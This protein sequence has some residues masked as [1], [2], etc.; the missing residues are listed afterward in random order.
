MNNAAAMYFKEEF[1]M[2]TASAAAVASVFGWMNLFARGLGGFVS[3]KA[4]AK[5]GMKGRLLWQTI[6]LF[7]E[8]VLVIVFA[9]SSK[10][11]YA[12]LTLICFS[13]FVQAGE[14]STYGVVPYVNPPVTGSV[15]GIVGAGGNVGAVVFGL[16]FQRLDSKLAFV[17]M[18]VIIIISSSFSF[19]V[20]IPGETR[21]ALSSCCAHQSGDNVKGVTS[22]DDVNELELKPVEMKLTNSAKTVPN[23][24][25]L[26]VDSDLM[27]DIEVGND[28]V[29][30]GN[31]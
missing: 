16:C 17:V 7:V 14:G 9:H 27:E 2:T 15:S 3:D 18:G 4:N 11:P 28:S 22:E 24:C 19:F 12:I 13:V 26:S 5:Q 21:L 1:D 8:G 25:D 31:I 10:L 30:N 29:S 20:N 23:D 6:C